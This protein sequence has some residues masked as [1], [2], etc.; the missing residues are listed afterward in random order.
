MRGY[1][2]FFG[3][4]DME[5]TL[6]EAEAASRP[7]M[8]FSLEEAKRATLPYEQFTVSAGQ[9]LAMQAAVKTGVR[10]VTMAPTL[11][12]SPVVTVLPARTG[13]SLGAKLA[14]GGLGL[15]ILGTIAYMAA[16]AEPAPLRP[17][18][19]RSTSRS[20]S[21][22]TP[23]SLP[24]G[25]SRKRSR[26]RTTRDEYEVRG[27]YGHGHGYEVVFTADTRLEAKNI[28]RD[29]RNNEP[30]VPFKIVRTRVPL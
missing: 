12:L 22:S 7:D 6:E 20:S 21:G 18:P 16:S 4:A 10:P 26:A 17:N 28:L 13:M 11:P 27:N 2:D 29:Y 3:T 5:F 15:A 8:E 25:A 1:D 19:K 24:S 9:P 14:L 30:G 23:R